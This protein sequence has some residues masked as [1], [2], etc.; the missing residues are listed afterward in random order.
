MP[1]F[2]FETLFFMNYDVCMSPLFK[3]S[4]MKHL[5]SLSSFL[6]ELNYLTIINIF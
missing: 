5:E 1:D 6:A 2:Y 4:D 3:S